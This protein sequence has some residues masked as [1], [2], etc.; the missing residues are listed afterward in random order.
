[1]D[2]FEKKNYKLIMFRIPYLSDSK[3]ISLNLYN[4]KTNK[5]KLKKQEIN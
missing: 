5:I 3:D 4:S 1:M 2:K